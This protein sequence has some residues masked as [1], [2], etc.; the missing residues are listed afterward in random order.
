MPSIATCPECASQ[1]A[2][3]ETASA[4]DRA[5]CPEC[6]TELVVADAHQRRLPVARILEPPIEVP[7]EPEPEEPVPVPEFSP[8]FRS[9]E[10]I[11]SDS[12]AMSGWE[13]RLRKAIDSTASEPFGERA[14]EATES[15]AASLDNAPEFEF[16]MDPPLESPSQ[17]FSA[18]PTELPD[19]RDWE[20]ELPA[21]GSLELPAAAPTTVAPKPAPAAPE[22]APVEPSTT[23][24]L[25]KRRSRK[26]SFVK[27][28][29]V[30]VVFGLIG[31]V[32]GQYA[33]LWLRGPSADFL[34]LAQIV[35]PA[36][37]PTPTSPVMP[38]Q[39]ASA[40]ESPQSVA[41]ESAAD[42]SLATASEPSEVPP[43]ES[44]PPETAQSTPEVSDV[45]PPLGPPP[46]TRDDAVEPATVELP[47]TKLLPATHTTFAEFAE[48]VASAQAAVPVLVSGDLKTS[49][50]AHA[51]GHA[52]MAFCRLAERFDFVNELG[53]AADAQHEAS[54]AQALFRTTAATVAPQNDFAVIV[55]RWWQHLKRPNQ[56]I[57][58]VG[59]IQD[60][61]T[62]SEHTLYQVAVVDQSESTLIPVLLDTT[63]YQVGDQLGVVG[64]IV[65]EPD[66]VLPNFQAN[67]PQLVVAQDSFV[68][69]AG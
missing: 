14:S 24:V 31:L 69:P 17:S 44:P 50:S 43:L 34:H 30:A 49:E 7:A 3:P 64:T 15:D 33:L 1:F 42:E 37:M 53:L 6:G 62:V 2:L 19:A 27:R 46:V 13:E 21:V 23:A 41:D 10:T 55:T 52:Y 26:S 61:Q 39:N 18:T 40:G 35:P 63:T 8:A 16:H 5:E 9:A 32:L 20:E 65:A 60:V 56:G 36:M 48:L 11:S 58:L 28:A 47:N 4:S 68:V 29:G 66:K 22:P 12:S 54:L 57:F 25:P 67:L 51:K 45:A 59:R 38:P